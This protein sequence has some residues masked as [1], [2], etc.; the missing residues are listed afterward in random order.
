MAVQFQ[1]L[2]YPCIL[3][4]DFFLFVY[5]TP[6]MLSVFHSVNVTLHDK[7]HSE[8]LEI[9]QEKARNI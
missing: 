8:Y 9:R 6:Y 7:H 3:L 4:F 2:E 5:L 1:F